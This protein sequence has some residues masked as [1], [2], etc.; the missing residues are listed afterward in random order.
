MEENKK[1]RTINKKIFLFGILPLLVLGTVFAVGYVVS[2]LVLTVGVAEP[3]TV[4]YAVLGDSGDYNVTED[5]TCAENEAWFSAG[6]TSVPGGVMY[7]EESRKF[8][9]KIDNAG[10][11][12]ID[13]AITSKIKEGLGNYADCAL[14]FPE[15]TVSGS[16]VNGVNYAG[17]EFTVPGD[18]LPVTG[19]EMEITV[20]RG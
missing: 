4:Q 16:A 19:C 12:P 13:Y 14:A 2:N 20:A 17:Q 1:K 6:D 18:A 10:E 11:S 3:F 9:V 8:C 5:G 7:P 15:T